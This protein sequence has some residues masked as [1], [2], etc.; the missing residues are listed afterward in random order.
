MSPVMERS[1][2]PERDRVGENLMLGLRLKEGAVVAKATTRFF[3]GVL[4]KYRDLGLLDFSAGSSRASLNLKGWLFSNRVF[5]DI[6][7]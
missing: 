7:S 5:L 3:G 6:L 4:E 1:T 2:L